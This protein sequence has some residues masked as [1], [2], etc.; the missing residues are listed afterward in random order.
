[1]STLIWH[2]EIE[3]ECGTKKNDTEV[4]Q[5]ILLSI[6]LPTDDWQEII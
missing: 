2:W 5:I 4:P 6:L 1:M 3:E